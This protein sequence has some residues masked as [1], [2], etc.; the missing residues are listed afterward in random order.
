V[1]LVAFPTGWDACRLPADTGARRATDEFLGVTARVELVAGLAR[2]L[3]DD[4]GVVSVG[5]RMAYLTVWAAG[6]TIG[7]AVA[8]V[9]AGVASK[10]GVFCQTALDVVRAALTVAVAV[11]IGATT[12]VV[13]PTTAMAPAETLITED[14]GLVAAL[15][16]RVV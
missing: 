2:G 10:F 13:R 4:A 3:A 9:D 8:L 14:I 5:V 1:E 6:L 15:F 11:G 16:I 12:D 7:A